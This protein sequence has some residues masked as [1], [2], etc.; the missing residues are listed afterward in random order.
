MKGLLLRTAWKLAGL[1]RGRK[2]I[3]VEWVFRIKSD[4]TFKSRFI[5][6]GYAQIAKINFDKTF[7]PV[8]RI[9]N[10][11]L[12]VT[13]AVFYGHQIR[14]TDSMSNNPKASLMKTVPIFVYY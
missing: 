4:G 8:V 14:H 3:G 9:E 10:V 5:G 7:A 6:K 12:V 11:R 13:L 2:A 1:P